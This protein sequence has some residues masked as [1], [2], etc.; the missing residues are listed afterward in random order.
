MP[1][2]WRRV[3]VG[4][5]QADAPVGALRRPTSTPSGRSASSRRRPARPWCAA[6]PGRSRRPGSENSWHQTSSPRSDGPHEPLALL[7]GAVLEDRRQRPAGDHEVG[8][9]RPRRGASSSSITIWVHRV[10]AE[11]VRRRPVRRQVAG[12][13]QRG[14]PR[15][16]AGSA[17]IRSAGLAHLGR[18]VR[19]AA[20]EVDVDAAAYAGD[21]E[22]SVSRRPPRRRRRP[23][24]A[25]RSARRR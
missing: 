20:L 19:V 23:A 25:A 17:P 14:P 21:R 18:I 4:A 13:D 7:V 3:R 1:L 8:P 16:S 24:R 22:R 2:C 10:G 5:G 15:R 6:R 12:L 9:G 11:A